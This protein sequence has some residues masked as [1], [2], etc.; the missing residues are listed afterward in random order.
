MKLNKITYFYPEKPVLMMIETDAFK[1]MSESKDWIAEPKFNGSRCEVHMLNGNVEFW[2]RHGKHL[3]YNSNSL[4]NDGRLNIIAELRKAFGYKGYF[5]LDGELRHNKVEGIQ[6]KLVIYDIHVYKNEVLNKLTFKERRNILESHFRNWYYDISVPV[7]L[8]NQHK[9]DFDGVFSDY[10]S[11]EWGNSDE[12]EG[13]V[14]KNINGKLNLSRSS[15]RKSNWM[16]KIRK[17][18]GRHRY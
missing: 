18:T 15:N 6:N 4:Y 16:F 7:H 9:T 17:Q 3:D 1:K 14:I 2:D 13:I 10:V 11:G 12:F 8:I 5:V